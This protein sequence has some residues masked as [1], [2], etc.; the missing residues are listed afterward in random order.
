M[1]LY[2][3]IFGILFMISFLIYIFFFSEDV[4]KHRQCREK[5]E[6]INSSFTCCVKTKYVDYENHALHTINFSDCPAY[7]SDRSETSGLFEFVSEGDTLLKKSGSEVV[8][9]RRGNQQYS[10]KVYLLCFE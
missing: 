4:I 9:V 5:E 2:L 1:R 10:F 6:F 3:R 8:V 7:I